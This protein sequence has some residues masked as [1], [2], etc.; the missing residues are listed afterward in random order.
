[1][2]MSQQESTWS[3]DDEEIVAVVEAVEGWE[4]EEAKKYIPADLSGAQSFFG[5]LDIWFLTAI[6]D[7]RTCFSCMVVDQFVFTGRELRPAFPWMQIETSDEIKANI[8][9]NCRC[10]LWRITTYADYISAGGGELEI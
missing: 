4:L 8:H 3:S 6:T 7:D 1:M 2:S 9:P 5:D 10:R